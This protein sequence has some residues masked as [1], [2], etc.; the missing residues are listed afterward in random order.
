M[1]VVIKELQVP[2]STTPSSSPRIAKRLSGQYWRLARRQSTFAH[3]LNCFREQ[4][5]VLPLQC[6]EAI[7]HLDALRRAV[8]TTHDFLVLLDSE[9]TRRLQPWACI[10]KLT[11]FDSLVSEVIL[12]MAMFT[13]ICQSLLPQRVELHLRIRSLLPRLH[14]TYQDTLSQLA[15]LLMHEREEGRAHDL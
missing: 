15:A 3:I 5:A 13:P 14:A 9:D 2:Y 11:V 7:A 8:Y 6:S 12:T 1:S 10:D 4:P